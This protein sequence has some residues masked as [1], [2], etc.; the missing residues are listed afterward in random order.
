M[1][2]KI[3]YDYSE[4]LDSY[5]KAI[6]IKPDSAMA[7]FFRAGSLVSLERGAE[8]LASMQ[9]VIDIEPDSADAANLREKAL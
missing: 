3:G 5:D 9:K 2:H 8:A 4:A 1:S 6:A 7:W